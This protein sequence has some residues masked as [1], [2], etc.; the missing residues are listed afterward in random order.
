MKFVVATVVIF[1]TLAWANDES[2]RGTFL[3]YQRRF[4]KLYASKVEEVRA[5][6][7]YVGNMERAA[8]LQKQNPHA[9]FGETEFTDMPMEEFRRTR[10]N[11]NIKPNALRAALKA[12]PTTRPIG[13][14]TMEW[15]WRDHGAVTHV[16]NQKDCG[17]CWSFSATG[18]MEGQWFLA[19]HNLTSL[20]EQLLVSCD[21]GLTNY[22]CNGGAPEFAI[23]WVESKCHGA[24]TANEYYPYVSGNGVN[25]PCKTEVIGNTTMAGAFV[26]GWELVHDFDEDAMS[27]WLAAHGPIGVCL[28]AES[29]NSYQGG[30]MTSCPGGALDLD[31]CVLL[32]GFNRSA[33]TPYWIIKNSW[34]VHW[35]EAGY[36]RVAFGH[37]LCHLAEVPYAPKAGTLP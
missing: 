34:G 32:V 24:W 6:E 5:F 25:P 8:E 20:S 9:Q 10:L 12:R 22:G 16:K 36:L 19:G 15:D 21:L 11:A 27:Q 1:A 18:A 3:S 30:V 28:D 35:G 7:A 23:S 37:D 4:N 33:S 17:S 31:H 26:D 2:L 14:T 13:N 29:W